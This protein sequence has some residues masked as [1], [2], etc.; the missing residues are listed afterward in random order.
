MNLNRNRKLV[1]MKYTISI[2]V[3][4]MVAILFSNILTLLAG[5]GNNSSDLLIKPALAEE[6]ELQKEVKKGL[7]DTGTE[8]KLALAGDDPAKVI[9]KM[10]AAILSLIGVIFLALMIYGGMLWMTARGNEEQITKAKS[11]LTSSSIGL[12]IILVAYAATAF[13]VSILTSAP[14]K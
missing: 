6:N 11:V 4:V 12:A 5:P 2:M 1:F 13:I 10:I 3:V 8:S 7:T 14:A 9:G